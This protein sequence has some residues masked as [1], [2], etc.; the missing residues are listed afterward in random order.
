MF[1][2]CLQQSGHGLVRFLLSL[3]HALSD[4]WY[5]HAPSPNPVCISLNVTAI[6]ALL[7]Y[8]AGGFKLWEGAVDLCAYLVE[9][10][11]LSQAGL[12][13]ASP[14]SSGLKV[15]PGQAIIG[16]SC[17][18]GCVWGGGRGWAGGRDTADR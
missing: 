9:S 2:L 1:R 10:H 7:S 15:S 11:G 17:G 5:T 4:S 6:I 8:V 13:G 18:C 16:S 3:R 12:L 14:A